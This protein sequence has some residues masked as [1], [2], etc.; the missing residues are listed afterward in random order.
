MGRHQSCTPCQQY[1]PQ[2][3]QPAG[4]GSCDSSGCYPSNSDMQAYNNMCR[5][6]GGCGNAGDNFQIIR[7]E[8]NNFGSP[9]QY[10]AAAGACKYNDQTYDRALR[11]AAAKGQPVVAIFGSKDTPD[12]Q[13]LLNQVAAAQKNGGDGATYVYIDMDRVAQNPNS[14]LAKFV[15]QN[16]R[17]HN[18]AHAMVFAQSPDAQGN[19][20][21]DAPLMRTWGGRDEIAG[22]LRDHVKYG[23]DAMRGRQF[24]VKAS[25]DNVAPAA[26][27]TDKP[28]T[29][30]ASKNGRDLLKDIQSGMEEGK[31]A[32]DWREGEKQYLK[33]I[34]A[35][36]QVDQTAVKAD[37]A[38]VQTAKQ[39]ADAKGDQTQSKE[40]QTQIEQLKTLQDAAWKARMEFGFS[41]MKWSPNYKDIGE[42]WLMSAGDRN[43]NMYNA[44][45]RARMKE[46][47]Y[48]PQTENAFAKRV[49][50]HELNKI[51]PVTPDQRR[52]VGPSSQTPA[53][54]T[55][56]P[57]QTDRR[58]P[59]L[60][61]RPPI[62]PD[63][64][65]R[66]QINPV[67]RP[68]VNPVVRPEV[69][70]QVRPENNPEVRP[71]IRP[72]EVTPNW[73][74]NG[75]RLAVTGEYDK[76]RRPLDTQQV[77]DTAELTMLEKAAAQGKV[78]STAFGAQWCH[79][80]PKQLDTF[81][82]NANRNDSVYYSNHDMERSTLAHQ[83][84]NNFGQAPNFYT[85]RVEKTG[86]GEFRL[87]NTATRQTYNVNYNRRRK[88]S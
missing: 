63:V 88:A 77:R 3:C 72:Q 10:N 30:A 70:P 14:P 62:N 21:P 52:D 12:T 86:D 15:D 35:A 68:Q 20:C 50:Q 7:P 43:P 40:L 82:S 22:L 18:L 69:V 23:Q 85:F 34:R 4:G 83:A 37:L 80:C 87:T 56:P 53:D 46:A 84:G 66:P 6:R 16:I 58:Y 29:P 78:L 28:A 8:A 61:G 32:T 9:E 24:N 75:G 17:G 47:G 67:V 5:T 38:K 54:R 81:Q 11:D 36:D 33:A 39:A 25:A 55:N 73:L 13:K 76:N 49:A 31:K 59:G 1:V 57:V 65:V 51:G 19:P 79:A 48:T 41:C 71:Q 64:R 2:E 45:F 26:D 44:E 42:Q 74:K 27:A 60:D